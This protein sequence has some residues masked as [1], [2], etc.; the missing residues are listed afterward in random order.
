MR[1]QRVCVCS[2]ILLFLPFSAD[3]YTVISLRS[4]ADAWAA[5]EGH[6]LPDEDVCFCAQT[7]S[8]IAAVPGQ[9]FINSDC[10]SA[11]N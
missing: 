5:A 11:S 10:G 2:I 3:I 6:V 8:E 1:Q 9:R 4:G 7:S